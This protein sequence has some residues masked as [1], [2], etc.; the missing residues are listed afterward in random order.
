[1]L[2]K[3]L[4]IVGLIG[5]VFFRVLGVFF[6]VLTGPSPDQRASGSRAT[7]QPRDGNVNVDYIPGKQKSKNGYKGGEYVDYEEL[8]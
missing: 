2:L 8:D 4:L 3:F 5:F 1:M 7:K 6:R